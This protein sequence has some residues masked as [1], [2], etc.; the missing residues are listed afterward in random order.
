MVTKSEAFP[1]KSLKAADLKGQPCTLR[2]ERAALENLRF[3]GKEQNKLVLYFA[4]TGKSL[5]V[6]ATNF[7]SLVELTGESDSDNWA[8]HV[9]E[10]Y[11]TTTEVRGETYDCIRIRAP[12][13]SD[14][15]AAAKSPNLPP[16]PKSAPRSAMDDEIPFSE[17]DESESGRAVMR[18]SRPLRICPAT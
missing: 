7:D 5:I 6:N 18:L 10:V 11:P 12:A 16:A 4:G 13:Q 14:M 9:V 2:V 1:T 15:L 8:G 3:N 17:G